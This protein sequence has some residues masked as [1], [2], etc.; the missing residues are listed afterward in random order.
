MEIPVLRNLVIKTALKTLLAIILVAI[1]LFGVFALFMPKPLADFFDYFG[2]NSASVTFYERHYNKTNSDEDLYTLCFKVDAV[3]DSER[4]Y[5]YLSKFYS[6]K[7]F[8]TYCKN[9]DGQKAVEYSTE[10]YMEGKLVLSAYL[11]K[12]IDVAMQKA[13]TCVTDLSGYSEYSPFR[14]L[15]SNPNV[16]L[17]NMDYQ[18]IMETLTEL[19]AQPELISN[20][21]SASADY[22]YVKSCLGLN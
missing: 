3:E 4:A 13:I 7:D 21:E 5:T 9:V 1:I 22:V 17:S 12:G 15:Y 6:D 16:K 10:D 8:Y 11:S 19:F 14:A 20:L 18:I 2:W